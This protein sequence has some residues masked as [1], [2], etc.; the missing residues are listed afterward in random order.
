MNFFFMDAGYPA[1]FIGF[2]HPE[3]DGSY[4][5]FLLKDPKTGQYEIFATNRCVST[6]EESCVVYCFFI[7]PFPGGHI[8][9]FPLRK[10][11]PY[12]EL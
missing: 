10:R 11:P 4:K 6:P 5:T 9:A 3:E 2:G 1:T 7:P 8:Y 12:S